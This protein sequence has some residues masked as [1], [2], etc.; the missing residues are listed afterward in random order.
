MAPSHQLL[1]ATRAP[2]SSSKKRRR[3]CGE[4]LG[5]SGPD[6]PLTRPLEAEAAVPRRKKKRRKRKPLEDASTA[7]GQA[8]VLEGREGPAE[9]P[10]NPL[11]AAGTRSEVNGQQ[12]GHGLGGQRSRKRKKKEAD[13]P[14][15]A[16]SL[17]LGTPQHR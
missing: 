5:G 13:R 11:E 2:Q 9:L 7:I 4:T 16:D 3:T 10:A 1:E 15:R 14:G 12:G 8:R 17:A 6:A